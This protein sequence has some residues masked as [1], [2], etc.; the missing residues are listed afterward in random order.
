M[1]ESAKGGHFFM[2]DSILQKPI[3]LMCALLMLLL[4]ALPVTADECLHETCKPHVPDPSTGVVDTQSHECK[5]CGALLQHQYQD[6]VCTI[7]GYV[8][9]HDVMV[10]LGD[11]H[12]CACGAV[13]QAHVYV[14]YIPDAAYHA[15]ADCGKTAPHVSDGGIVTQEPTC[16]TD[17]VKTFTC[18]VCSATLGTEPIP[19]TGE[20]TWDE[21]VVTT[22]ATCVSDGVRTFTCSV[23]NT[24]KTEPIPATGEHTWDD[25]A[26][27]TPATCGQ[28]GIRTYTCTVCQT[29]RTESIPATGEHAWDGGVV[30]KP[31]TCDQTGV[32]TYTC[33]VCKS[34]IEETI[35]APGHKWDA[36]VVTKSATC[37]EPG[38]RKYTC[39]VCG[40]TREESIPALPHRWTGRVVVAP[41]CTD[42]GYTTDYCAVCGAWRE[43]DQTEA[44]GHDFDDW[45]LTRMPTVTKTGLWER[46]CRECDYVQTATAA[47]LEAYLPASELTL[48]TS[49]ADTPAF[50]I[51][52][53]A[54]AASLPG[55]TG[56]F[57][58]VLD[59]SS[60]SWRDADV[61]LNGYGALSGANV[62]VQSAVIDRNR[63]SRLTVQIGHMNVEGGPGQ[64][65]LSLHPERS[66]RVSVTLDADGQ[67]AKLGTIRLATAD[68]SRTAAETARPWT[69][70]NLP[71]STQTV[72]MTP[73]GSVLST[74]GGAVCVTT[75]PPYL[76]AVSGQVM[77]APA[78]LVPLD[79]AYDLFSDGYTMYIQNG[80][81]RAAFIAGSSTAML[82]DQS[83]ALLAVPVIKGGKLFVAASDLTR[84]TGIRVQSGAAMDPQSISFREA[85]YTLRIGETATPIVLPGVP[86]TGFDWTLSLASGQE[87]GV[88]MVEGKTVTALGAGTVTLRATSA[89]GGRTAT[90]QLTVSGYAPG[91]STYCVTSGTVNVRAGAG[92]NYAKLDTLK[93]GDEVTVVGK[94]GNWARIV[95]GGAQAFVSLSYLKEV[96]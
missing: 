87:Q 1:F 88:A 77:I 40:G 10:D 65:A 11:H 12:G 9:Q 61:T 96:K 24:Q 73:G 60:G 85:A 66:A 17:G 3:A 57:T 68:D 20:H 69:P 54:P 62:F 95:Y 23:C 41:T 7:C 76:D 31:A 79:A 90:V 50:G 49:D 74:D 4:T 14:P 26:V 48:D 59:L 63:P 55:D 32:K 6:G 37:K 71:A 44:L 51:V 2:K 89:T 16:N 53:N 39:S 34:T 78:D 29:P 22:P 58:L 80:D 84:L 43:Y 64:L 28:A 38:T 47:K 75:T 93:R 56:T 94:T 46:T 13:A 25:G 18:S 8:C 42:E 81:A 27:T 15:C 5:N 19:A 36:G 21:G 70:A 45:Q 67:R 86:T 33:S 83:E 82:A 30:T 92:T 91:F 52:L 35:P 72:F